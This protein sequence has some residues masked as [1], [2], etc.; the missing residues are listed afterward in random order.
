MGQHRT[1]NFPN[2]EYVFLDR[3][4]VV[5]RSFH[6]GGYIRYWEQF[7]LLPGA[8]DAIVRLNRSGRKVVLVTNQ[9]GIARGL[10]TEPELQAL[11]AQLQ[12]HLKAL[13]GHLDG[14][15]YCPHDD[16]QCA[17]RKPQTGVLEQAF[18]DFPGAQADNSV[19]IGDSLC[20]VEA[21]SRM[22]M[23]TVFVADPELP[24]KSDAARAAALANVSAASLLDFVQRYLGEE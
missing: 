21:G 6:P 16:G 23:L 24:P 4:G 5:N 19:M 11:H 9:S 18:L 1:N 2:I 10:C 7:H 22:G 14:I 8:G 20:D 3:D 15:Y 17:C 12:E 13:G